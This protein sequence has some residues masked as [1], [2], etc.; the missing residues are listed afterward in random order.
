MIWPRKYEVT[1]TYIQILKKKCVSNTRLQ[2]F[3]LKLYFEGT[4]SEFY[5]K[6]VF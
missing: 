2:N 1:V 5:T 6:I 4:I 3:I